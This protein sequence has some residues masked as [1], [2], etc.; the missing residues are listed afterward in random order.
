[1]YLL[2]GICIHNHFHI[3]H[4][5]LGLN[6]AYVFPGVGTPGLYSPAG[7]CSP[8]AD[9]GTHFMAPA[10]ATRCNS[11]GEGTANCNLNAECFELSIEIA[12]KWRIAPEKW[13]FSVLKMAIYFAIRGTEPAVD[14]GSC[15]TCNDGF[16]SPY[17]VCMGCVPGKQ[18]ATDRTS[19]EACGSVDAAAYSADGTVCM[20]CPCV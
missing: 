17:G 20:S 2:R 10:A 3:F 19:C 18:S 5:F 11:C 8:C 1:M 13:W 16:Y 15:V 12:E 7:V 4:L 14:R 6:Y 9:L